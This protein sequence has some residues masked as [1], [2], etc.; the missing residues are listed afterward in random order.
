MREAYCASTGTALAFGGGG[1]ILTGS[2][3]D[4]ENAVDRRA[5]EDA[6]FASGR[7]GAPRKR[8]SAAAITLCG[9]GLKRRAREAPL[10][11]PSAQL[12]NSMPDRAWDAAARSCDC[13]HRADNPLQSHAGE[14]LEGRASFRPGAPPVQSGRETAQGGGEV[15]QV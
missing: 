7:E 1:G 10:S 4:P 8:I 3:K 2:V 11:S 6:R 15:F 5:R 12:H 14:L 9:R 13:S